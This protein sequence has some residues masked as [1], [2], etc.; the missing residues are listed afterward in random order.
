M[1]GRAALML[2]DDA[3]ML[4]FVLDSDGALA[5]DDDVQTPAIWASDAHLARANNS[6]LLP[7][8]F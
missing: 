6:V 8:E 4:Q 3:W 5:L 7:L 2:D 1:H